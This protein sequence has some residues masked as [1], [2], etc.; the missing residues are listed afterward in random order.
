MN[1]IRKFTSRST[2]ENKQNQ[3]MN[4]IVTFTVTGLDRKLT[5]VNAEYTKHAV[6]MCKTIQI[7]NYY[8]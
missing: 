8:A 7:L 4:R 3:L 1:T 2:N 6:F 5:K